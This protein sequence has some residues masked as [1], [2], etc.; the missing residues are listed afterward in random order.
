MEIVIRNV[1]I[2]IIVLHQRVAWF[3][4]LSIYHLNNLVFIYFNH[5]LSQFWLR[6]KG[7]SLLFGICQCIYGRGVVS[8]EGDLSSL[9]DSVLNIQTD[10]QKTV[11]L[12]YALIRL[13]KHKK[14]SELC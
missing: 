9:N 5:A 10:K 7:T 14:P 12:T 13:A 1:T 11:L 6:I 8:F 3:I 2:N 4:Y